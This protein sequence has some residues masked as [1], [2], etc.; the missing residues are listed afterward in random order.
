MLNVTLLLSFNTPG[1]GCNK[2]P[3]FCE[4]F[5][6]PSDPEAR[7]VLEY[8]TT[9][10]YAET[11]IVI[12]KDG[13][14]PGSV[15]ASYKLIAYESIAASSPIVRRL[16]GRILGDAKGRVRDQK[17]GVY[18]SWSYVLSLIVSRC[19]EEA[20]KKM[21]GRPKRGGTAVSEPVPVP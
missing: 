11:Q 13:F 7:E 16:S 17:I 21:V 8:A 4:F 2:E 3:I 14:A 12:E 9:T 1:S 5:S 20:A 18:G 6:I 15:V 10:A 19:F